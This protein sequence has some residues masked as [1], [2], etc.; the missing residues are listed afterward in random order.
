M[1]PLDPA[2]T[3]ILLEMLKQKVTKISSSSDGQRSEGMASERVCKGLV[4]IEGANGHSRSGQRFSSIELDDRFSD[5]NF[6][7]DDF[8]IDKSKNQ[9]VSPNRTAQFN[10]NQSHGPTVPSLLQDNFGNDLDYNKDEQLILISGAFRIGKHD[11]GTDL[12]ARSKAVSGEED[13]SDGCK[14]VLAKSLK[15]K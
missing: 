4:S 5:E 3:N 11:V 6:D 12:E 1:Q 7:D 2:Q 14:N 9:M 15:K 8:T 10:Q 13:N